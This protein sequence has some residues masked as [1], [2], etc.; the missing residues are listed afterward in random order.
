VV[1]RWGEVVFHVARVR[2]CL[3]SVSTLHMGHS[4]L[5]MEAALFDTRV[6]FITETNRIELVLSGMQ[7]RT[8][9]PYLAAIYRIFISLVLLLHTS[10]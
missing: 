1:S 6:L 5:H 10:W 3:G 4:C 7:N 8:L 2:W 9:H